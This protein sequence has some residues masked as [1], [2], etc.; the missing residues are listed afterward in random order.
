[1]E[2][3]GSITVLA[4]AAMMLIGVLLV[5]VGMLGGAAVE[6]ARAQTAADAAALA[7]AVH[8]RAEAEAV[9]AANEGVLVSYDEQAADADE[10]GGKIGGSD[11][12]TRVVVVV[13]VGGARAT[14]S[15]TAD[16]S[17]GLP[18]PLPPDRAWTP[19]PGR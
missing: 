16:V 12:G 5:G 1:M 11:G 15:A 4:A 19:P 7:G 14:A 10:I 9:A 13:D 6:R 8:G 3:R 2:E 17:G 18:D